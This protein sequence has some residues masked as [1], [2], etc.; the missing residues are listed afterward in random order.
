MKMEIKE[1]KLHGCRIPLNV[2][3]VAFIGMAD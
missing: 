1:N 3:A 2:F